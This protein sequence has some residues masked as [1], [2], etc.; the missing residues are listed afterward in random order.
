MCMMLYGFGEQLLRLHTSEKG[1]RL[2]RAQALK[3]GYAGAAGNVCMGLALLGHTAS[4][5]SK[6]PSNPLGDGAINFLRSAGVGVSHC[7]RG[8]GR[9]GSYFIEAGASLRPG[10][11]VYDRKNSFFSELRTGEI[12]W[13]SMLSPGDCLY[14]SGIPLALSKACAAE[15]LRAA[16][17]AKDLGVTVVF[18]INFRRSLWKNIPWATASYLGL[19]PYVDVLFGNTGGVS[20]VFGKD[21]KGKDAVTG[22]Q[23]AM[24]FVQTEFPHLELAFTVREALS[25]ERHRVTALSRKKGN[26]KGGL[27]LDVSIVDRVGAGDAFAAAYL[28]G[29]F[30]QWDHQRQ[31]NFAIASFALN[32][33]INGDVQWLGED[34]ILAAAE[35][36]NQPYL[37]R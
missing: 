10:K 19:F 11:V 18:D 31:L 32:H 21:F 24:D 4:F 33:T 5:V 15:T 3:V 25:A 37:Q 17:I 30:K 1:A 29:G 27:T 7:I 12:D 8:T 23:M 35:G 20:D 34:E 13:G 22:T 26:T 28:H 2:E 16:Q 36:N 6:L 14:L 9:M